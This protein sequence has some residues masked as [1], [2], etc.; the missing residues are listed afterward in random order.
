M[1][2]GIHHAA[3]STSDL[4]RS[5]KFYRDLLGFKVTFELDFGEGDEVLQ[6]LMALGGK[7]AGRL[8]LLRADNAFIELFQFTSPSPQPVDP[9]RPVC[10]HGL[11]HVCLAVTDIDA[12]YTRL[13]AAGMYFHCPVQEFGNL[14]VTYGRDP[15]GNVVELLQVPDG[16]AMALDR[17]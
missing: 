5:L 10:D 17:S 11:T 2:K 9:R 1:I 6:R 7:A 15:D 3:I 4:D 14:R 13:Q 8:A 12:E 16:D